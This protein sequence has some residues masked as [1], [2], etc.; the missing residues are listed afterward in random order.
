MIIRQHNQLKKLHPNNQ[1]TMDNDHP[2]YDLQDR[3]NRIYDLKRQTLELSF[4]QSPYIELL[5]R[6]SNPHLHLPPTIHIAG[7]NGKGSTLAFLRSIY[8]S[9]GYS[10]HAYTSPHLIKFNERIVMNGQM[11]SDSLLLDYLNITDR[12]KDDLSVGFS[13]YITAMAMK[14]FADHPADLCILE[15]GLGGRLDPTNVIPSPK[16]TVITPIGFYHMD[17]LGNSIEQIAGEKAGIMKQNTPCIIAQQEYK[18]TYQVFENRSLSIDAPLHLVQKNYAESQVGLQGEHQKINA[19]TAMATAQT[20]NNQF[21]ITDS[22]CEN[23][24]KSCEWPARMEKITN[25]TIYNLLPSQCDL[26]FDGG[27]NSQGAKIIAQQLKTWKKDKNCGK[28]HVIIGMNANKDAH[29]FVS[30]FADYS[31]TITCVD[32]PDARFPQTGKQLSAKLTDFSTL[33]INDIQSAIN[34]LDPQQK[35][36]ILICGSLYLYSKL[37]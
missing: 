2:D 21:P 28:I 16:V 5:N 4:E 11:I 15:T 31:D 37:W 8:E 23:G 30:K 10:V 6:L 27:H 34:I 29:S 1:C 25:G 24:L 33:G 14:I 22:A 17:Y 13:E 18:A 7:T 19:A 9:S 26:W 32:L 12:A 3:L 20:L 35:D 36:I